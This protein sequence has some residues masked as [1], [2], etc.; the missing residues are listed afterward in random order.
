[1][2]FPRR[3]ASRLVLVLALATSAAC[4]T[5]APRPEGPPTTPPAARVPDLSG[6]LGVQLYS[7]RA[8]MDQDPEGTL[9]RVREM[10]FEAVEV[11]R[12]F[13]PTAAEFRARLD[14][15]GLRAR[16]M[17]TPFVRLQEDLEGLIAD[18]KALGVEFVTCPWIPHEGEF[19]DADAQRAIEVF[20]AAGRAL[21]AAGLRFTYHIHGYELH[22]GGLGETLLDR[23]LAQTEPGV[24][25]FEMDVFYM[26]HGGAD[27]VAYLER[28]PGRFPL[29]HLKDM[30]PGTPTG[31]RTGK[32]DPANTVAVGSGTID[33]PAVIAAAERQ[34]AVF[35]FVEDESPS[36]P[37]NLPRSLG[38]L[39]AA[40]P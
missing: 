2:K 33:M 30:K 34:G 7:V 28:Y 37:E 8:L 13:A 19:S 3:T 40:A 9:R 24:V 18:A 1:M 22:P 29:L 16:G 32:T 4:A 26:V 5:K 23:M 38:Y 35:Y 36:A 12:I 25:D 17:M 21:K 6:K 11:H 10:G 15:A 31:L 14:A 27:P 39:R 20:T